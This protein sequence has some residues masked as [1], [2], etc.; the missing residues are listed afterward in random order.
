MALFQNVNNFSF[1]GFGFLPLNMQILFNNVEPSAQ[2]IMA[3]VY[4][5]SVTSSLD[6]EREIEIK[7]DEGS[8]NQAPVTVISKTCSEFMDEFQRLF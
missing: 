4:G 6:I 5:Q 3:T 7:F 2:K 1:L 8:S